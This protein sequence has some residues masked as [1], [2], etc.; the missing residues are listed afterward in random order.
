M[1]H[2]TAVFLLAFSSLAAAQPSVRSLGVEG[3]SFKLE[4]DNGRVLRSPEL[5]GAVQGIEVEGRMQRVRI[6]AVELDTAS[7]R[8]D[9]WLHS[10]SLAQAD[11]SWKDL[12]ARGPDG[13][14]QGFPLAG[15]TRAN[16]TLDT[17]DPSVFE[18]ACTA[19]GQAKC[20]RLGYAPWATAPDGTSL[21]AAHDACVLML[22]ADYGGDGRPATV[23]G[24]RIDVTDRWGLRAA[25][26][27]DYPFEAGWDAQGAVCV[28]HPRRRGLETLAR[29][30]ARVP[31][32]KGATG[33]ACTAG[34]ARAL[35]ALVFNRSLP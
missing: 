18:L 10:L 25:R 22:R 20:V 34:R 31:R 28:H 13:R 8:D 14:A 17:R 33:R 35:G 11:G 24:V 15:R 6:D 27:T 4:L 1:R 30:E 16:G 26:P 12:C 3:S 19:G 9:V 32:L 5:A 21:K 7:G 2:A 23:D 29:L